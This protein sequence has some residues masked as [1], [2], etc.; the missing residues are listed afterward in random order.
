MFSTLG[1]FRSLPCPHHDSC[2]LQNC[3]F[4]HSLNTPEPRLLNLVPTPA[5]RPQPV[6]SS[7]SSYPPVARVQPLPKPINIIP[8]K[9]P[10]ISPVKTTPASPEPPRKVQKL[11]PTQ[12]STTVPAAAR[13]ES[14]VPILRVNAAQSQVALPV[15][16]TMLK[17]L[18]EHF[19][20]LYQQLLP[21]NPSLA[22]DH[23]LKQ[24]EEVYSK[25][26]KTTYRHAVIQCVA[27]LKRRPIPTSLNDSSVGTEDEIASR[28]EAQ[29]QI[30]CLRLTQDNLRHLIHTVDELQKWGYFIDVPPEEGGTQP[31]AEGKIVRCDRCPQYYLAKRLEEA[32][33]CIYHWG[34]PYMTRIGGEKI[35]MYRCCQRP[36]SDGEGCMHGPHVFSEKDA[37]ALHSRQAFSFL[38]PS[39]PDN[40]T[41]LD[42]AAMD[43]EMVY[44]TGGLRVAR[45][46]VIDGAEKEV[47]DQLVQMDDGVEVIDYN[48]RFSGIN[49]EIHS[50]AT[51]KLAGI[52]S[53]LDQLIDSNTILIGHALDNDLK[54]LR[55]IHHRC[56]DTALLFPHKAGSPYRRSLKDL[57]REKLGKMIQTGSATEGHSSVE[58]A[59]AT[60]DLVRWFILNKAKSAILADVAP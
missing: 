40:S 58:D 18:Y 2:S 35:R 22:A 56:I 53:A 36:V 39:T 42:V 45:V 17:T 60:L 47:F 9:R 23:A 26:T 52:R 32:D 24:E 19:C 15:R 44:S 55:I 16:Q 38:Q 21:A 5:P 27:I 33:Q 6:A 11:G 14:G 34:R 41:K 50:Q 30:E 48:T 51:L 8:A 49:Q 7:S 37:E 12:K 29:K 13:T 43:C 25:S 28:A 4:S 57:T 54:T 1:L 59:A 10:A 3:L 20:V 31:S 46:S